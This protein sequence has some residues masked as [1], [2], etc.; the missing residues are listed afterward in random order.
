MPD[1]KPRSP[2]DADDALDEALPELDDPDDDII[3]LDDELLA[4]EIDPNFYQNGGVT[5]SEPEI[6]AL[7]ELHG[8]RIL[9]LGAGNG[10]DICSLINLG[11]N[12]FVIDDDES[13]EPARDLVQGAGLQAEFIVDDPSMLSVDNRNADFDL[14]YSGFGAIDWVDDL[15][16]W[17][18][19]IADS[20]RSDGRLV[21][22]DE[23]PIGY[24]FGAD[25][26]SLTVENSYFGADA[27]P[28][29]GTVDG[30]SAD[31]G[32]TWTVGDIITA[33]GANGLATLTLAEFSESD[34]FESVLDRL[35]DVD[36]DQLALIPST[37]LL[38]AQKL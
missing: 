26:G 20:L 15:D 23:H 25:D 8:R 3:D 19:G 14:V 9:V 12:V 34:R 33:L 10:E 35:A 28:G 6:E 24:V 27:E 32:P 1:D 16:S 17:A 38:V 21:A 11:A 7:G 37:L 36:Q 13:I 31:N 5:L 30:E 29:A 2:L 18:G 4:E 22:Y